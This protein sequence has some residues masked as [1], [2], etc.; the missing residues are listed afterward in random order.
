M[1][2]RSGYRVLTGEEVETLAGKHAHEIVESIAAGRS[3][4]E[5]QHERAKEYV[6]DELE[7]VLAD[8]RIEEGGEDER[9]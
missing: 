6:A 5:R 2:P 1:T 3:L 4:T 9:A 7:C 8:L